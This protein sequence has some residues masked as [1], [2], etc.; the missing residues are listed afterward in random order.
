M[1]QVDEALGGIYGVIK[2]KAAP[3]QIGKPIYEGDL[4]AMKLVGCKSVGDIFGHKDSG[5]DT[6][7]SRPINFGSKAQTAM[8]PDATR[9]R[10]FELKKMINDAEV[11]AQTH[12]KT[13]HPTAA[14]IMDTGYFKHRLAPVLKS[15]NVTD[16]SSWIN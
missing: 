12:F 1:K 5:D 13:A 7:R 3:A 15:F 8:L 6:F 14:Q 4:D 2:D 11:I 9:L 10:M 16:F